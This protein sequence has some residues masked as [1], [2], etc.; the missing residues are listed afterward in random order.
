MSEAKKSLDSFRWKPIRAV[1][2][3]ARMSQ[4]LTSQM[5]DTRPRDEMAIECSVGET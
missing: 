2:V 3:I 4:P 1:E 5:E